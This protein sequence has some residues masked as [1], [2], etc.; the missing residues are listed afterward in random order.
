MHLTFLIEDYD[1]VMYAMG[2]FCV[3]IIGP[4]E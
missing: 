1:A 3:A 2:Y 4:S